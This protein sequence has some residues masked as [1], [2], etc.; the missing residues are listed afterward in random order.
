[1][2]VRCATTPL[3]NRQT[4]SRALCGVACAACLVSRLPFRGRCGGHCALATCLGAISTRVDGCGL[5]G[6]SA[7]G[8]GREWRGTVQA[9]V[10]YVLRTLFL[11]R[12]SVRPGEFCFGVDGRTSTK[13]Q[14][15]CDHRTANMLLR[16]V[17]AARWRGLTKGRTVLLRA[18][19]PSV[20]NRSHR[21]LS[22]LVPEGPCRAR[23]PAAGR[24]KSCCGRVRVSVDEARAR[25]RGIRKDGVG[26][27]GGRRHDGRRQGRNSHE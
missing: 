2:T 10:P 8:C 15:N 17:F 18:G 16:W 5:C 1:M 7:S 9:V 21:A 25:R 24:L 27:S 13:K 6:K 4:V 26:W 14:Y 3:R 22:L 11:Y 23:C 19:R 12:D 20:S